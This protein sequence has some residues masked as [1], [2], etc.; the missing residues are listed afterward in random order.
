VAISE[1]TSPTPGQVDSS[2]GGPSA[3]TGTF[4][5]PAGSLLVAIVSLVHASGTPS[6]TVSNTG[7]ALTWT[8]QVAETAGTQPWAAI[9]TAPNPASQSNITVTAADSTTQNALLQVDVRVVLGAASSQ[10]GAATKIATG[11]ASPGS[12]AITTTTV[13]SWVYIAFGLNDDESITVSGNTTT[14]NSDAASD[15]GAAVASGRQATATTSPGA[16]TLGWTF[17]TSANWAIAMLEIL[18][19]ASGGPQDIPQ[20]L[21]GPMWFDLFKPGFPDPRPVTPPFPALP[22]VNLTGSFALAPLALSG[23]G[24]Q[25]SPDI[26]QINPGSTW[27]SLFKGWAPRPQPVPPAVQP[28]TSSGSLSLA[29]LKLSGTGA[30]TS[31]DLPGIA[32]GSTWLDLFK[33]QWPKPRPP[34]P[35]D[36]TGPVAASGGLALGTLKFSATGAQTSPDVPQFLPGPLWLSLFKPWT[37]QRLKLVSP[38]TVPVVS[39]SGSIAL[40]P[41]ALS[42][43]A[44]ET[45]PDQPQI[46]PGPAWFDLFK[47]QWQRPRQVTPPGP[48]AVSAMG[49]L[50]LAPL[51]LSGTATVQAVSPDLPQVLPGPAW[52]HHFKPG[53]P[54]PLPP[55]AVIGAVT[56]SG[57]FALAP[58]AIS[59]FAGYGYLFTGHYSLYY[60]DYI[61]LN[62]LETLF[63]VPGLSYSMTP[64]NH[65][66][67]S[68]PPADGRWLGGSPGPGDEVIRTRTYA[69]MLAAGRAHN[70]AM[71]AEN[72]KKPYFQTGTSLPP[73]QPPRAVPNAE[74]AEGRK[75]NAER[76]ARREK[77]DE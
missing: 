23:T 17:G 25:T 70:A 44:A 76:Q 53:L 51:A 11:S 30:Q 37:P 9:Y 72:A 32:P 67:L 74:L 21:P 33:P 6:F 52:L 68:V 71:Q 8:Q 38:V 75:V 64:V 50:A 60:L 65:G 73:P 20:I 41:L 54:R 40:A 2:S 10:T 58:L 16:T 62:T 61:D 29:P 1:G 22:A 47:P 48:P 4:S 7:S 66:G 34:V 19:A 36:P 31:P 15:R 42:G 14:I 27:L 39:I 49:S 56:S 43:T 63:A 24:A 5:P 55:A 3:T 12:A 35:P 18:P 13:G 69:E 28:V 57:S 45:S 59:G 77:T 26:P 46:Q